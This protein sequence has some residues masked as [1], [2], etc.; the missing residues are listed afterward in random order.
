[1][2][3]QHTA[4]DHPQ[5]SRSSWSRTSHC[6]RAADAF[7]FG[8]TL[9]DPPEVLLDPSPD[10][11]PEPHAVEHL[12]AS[13]ADRSLYC[14]TVCVTLCHL[15][16]I[17]RWQRFSKAGLEA[18]TNRFQKTSCILSSTR[19]VVDDLFSMCSRSHTTDS[20]HQTSARSTPTL[21]ADG[22]KAPSSRKLCSLVFSISSRSTSLVHFPRL[23]CT[24]TEYKVT[25]NLIVTVRNSSTS[26]NPWEDCV[27]KTLVN[28]GHFIERRE[29]AA[30]SR[31]AFTHSHM[32]HHRVPCV[33]DHRLNW[34]KNKHH[35]KLQNKSQ[36]RRWKTAA[37]GPFEDRKAF[38][39]G[40]PNWKNLY[41]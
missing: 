12:S 4:E 38:E 33:S 1:M 17:H 31:A 7:Y 24:T 28:V 29:L 13:K 39:S 40:L 9:L 5:R 36:T 22:K 6:G 41:L 16:P 2:H 11:P 37:R 30:S 18:E 35:F 15:V 32:A 23:P 26:L 10:R 3:F 20:T 19:Q 8:W 14:V 25:H 34:R 27:M 21:S